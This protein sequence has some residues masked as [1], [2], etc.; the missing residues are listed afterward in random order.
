M[1]IKKNALIVISF[2]IL[3]ILVSSSCGEKYPITKSS[4]GYTF[5]VDE[6][7][8]ATLIK[9]DSYSEV[10]EVPQAIDSYKVIKLGSVKKAALVGYTYTGIFEYNDIVKEIIIPEGLQGMD[11]PAIAN[12]DNLERISIPSTMTDFSVSRCNNL[13]EVSIADGSEVVEDFSFDDCHK[14]ENIFL[15]ERIKKISE[16][17]F[18]GCYLL[19]DIKM[20]N[21]ICTIEMMAFQGCRSL[22]TIDLPTELS[23]IDG[24]AFQLSGLESISIPQNVTK[25]Q[26]WTFESCESLK[27]V[28]LSESIT[29]IFDG[30][31]QNCYSLERIDIYE[32]CSYIAE[33]AFEGCNKLTIYGIKGSYAEKYAKEHSIPF[34]A[35]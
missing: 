4:D 9:A 18:S 25:I 28:Q 11:G 13:K 7:Q 24:N 10:I 35:L 15:P 16:S 27:T 26:C 23:E 2:G 32:K 21:S 5:Q 14:L 8:N 6:K 31:F 30:A 29:N 20:S 12:C 19:K 1:K 17:A 22:K 3:M 34:V 33:N